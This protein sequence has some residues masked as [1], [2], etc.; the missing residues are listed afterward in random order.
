MRQ[1]DSSYDRAMIRAT[2][3]AQPIRDRLEAGETVTY[4]EIDNVPDV[5]WHDMQRELDIEEVAGVGHRVRIVTLSAETR[6]ILDELGVTIIEETGGYVRLGDD[7]GPMDGRYPVATVERAAAA[8]ADAD[9]F[10]GDEDR[11]GSH[12]RY[13][14]FCDALAHE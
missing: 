10:A 14:A 4:E 3:A 5:A 9:V 11:E 2:I 8:V 12:Y 13:E 7:G 1:I 6:E